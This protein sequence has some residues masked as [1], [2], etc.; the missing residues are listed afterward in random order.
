MLC[1]ALQCFLLTAI[2]LFGSGCTTVYKIES[3]LSTSPG[4]EVFESMK[5]IKT[6]NVD[7]ALHIDK[8]IRELEVSATSASDPNSYIV[9]EHSFPMGS[10][11]SAKFIKT[12]SYN[13]RTIHLI[14]NSQYKGQ[15]SVDAVMTITLQDVD[16]NLPHYIRLSIRAEIRDFEENKPIWIGTTGHATQSDA[17]RSIPEAA[18]DKG[19]D[20][21][22]GDL[23]RQMTKSQNLQKYLNKWEA[24]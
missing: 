5:K 3:A 17:S 20:K 1:F 8:K 7:L 14:E 12:L 6:R 21:A 18:I 2:M 23:I 22:I 10:A 24:K 4:I 13:F 15:D 9:F 16:V 19:I 11:F